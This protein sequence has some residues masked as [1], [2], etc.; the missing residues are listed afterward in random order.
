MVNL[1]NDTQQEAKHKGSFARNGQIA[2][3]MLKAVLHYVGTHVILVFRWFGRGLPWHKMSSTK[4]ELPEKAPEA[5]TTIAV[6]LEEMESLPH[7]NAALHWG[8]F[9]LS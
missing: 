3:H 6:R 5:K 8:A 9:A 4:E 7:R 1:I 2:V